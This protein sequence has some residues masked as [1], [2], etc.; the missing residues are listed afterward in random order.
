MVHGGEDE[1]TPISQLE[2]LTEALDK[3]DYPYETLIRENEG[4]GFYKL[5]NRKDFF[6]KL[7][8]FLDKNIRH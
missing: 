8:D 6:N 1:R 4:H 7:L 3:V 5:S 2:S